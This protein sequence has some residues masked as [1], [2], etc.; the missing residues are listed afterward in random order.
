[1]VEQNQV[2]LRFTALAGIGLLAISGPWFATH[3]V[4][5][6]FGHQQALGAPLLSFGDTR[7]YSPFAIFEW[8]ER[9]RAHYHARS[10]SRV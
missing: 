10:R 1:M 5:D 9:F 7:L 8:N 6:I 3:F 4:A 2:V